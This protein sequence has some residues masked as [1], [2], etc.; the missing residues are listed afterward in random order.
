MIISWSG[1][2]AGLRL[3][4]RRTGNLAIILGSTKNILD[5]IVERVDEAVQRNQPSG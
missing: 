2:Q 4:S 1:G 3:T 5:F